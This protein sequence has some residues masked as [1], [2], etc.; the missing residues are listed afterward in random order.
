MTR[1]IVEILQYNLK[2]GTGKD[3]H[4][5]MQEISVPLHARHSIE[6][7]FYGNSLHNLDCYCLIRAFENE[8]KMNSVLEDFYSGSDWRNGPR[9]DII[10]KIDNSIKSIISLPLSAV[11]EL[12]GSKAE[13]F[14]KY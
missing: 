6:V 8:E 14:I 5:I 10:S 13:D 7:I 1:K 12:K 9:E 11:E 3:F 4:Q 2:E